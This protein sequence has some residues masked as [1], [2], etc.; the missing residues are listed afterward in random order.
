MKKINFQELEPDNYDEDFE[1]LSE[2]EI[3][4]N[5]SKFSMKKLADVIVM[6]RY[7]GIYKDLAISAMEE[8]SARRS[9][10]NNF[11]YEEYIN[12]N[13][14]KLPKINFSIPSLNNII[15]NLKGFRK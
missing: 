7:I 1:E 15:D 12:D 4:K 6:S 9:N 3:K 11:N 13:F 8:L 14:N 5:I 2:E 10:G